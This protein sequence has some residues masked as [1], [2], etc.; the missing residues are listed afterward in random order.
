MR[1]YTRYHLPLCRRRPIP[2]GACWCRDSSHSFKNVF[3]VSHG[4]T[5]VVSIQLVTSHHD[6]A[7]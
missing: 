3:D 4:K 5:C 1:Y 6:H 2:N 7:E